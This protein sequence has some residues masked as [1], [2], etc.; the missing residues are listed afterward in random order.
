MAVI[1]RYVVVRNGVEL[2]QVFEVK[3]EADAYDKML[4]AAE[5]LAEFI[6][7]SDLDVDL[8]AETVDAISICLAKNAPEVTKILKGIK[9]IAA[10]AD[11]GGKIEDP[12]DPESVKSK[13]AIGKKAKSKR[14]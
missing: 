1:T 5:H 11:I 8:N 14:K 9:P 4:D 10:P 12:V 6:K 2:D 3:K 7:Q 13:K